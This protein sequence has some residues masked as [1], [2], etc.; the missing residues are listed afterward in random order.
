MLL[1]AD[2]GATTEMDERPFI[3]FRAINWYVSFIKYIIRFV[4]E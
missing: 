3:Y 2:T 4:K 1:Q